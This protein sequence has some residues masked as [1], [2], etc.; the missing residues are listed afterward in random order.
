MTR[1][2]RPL[3]GECELTDSLTP[4]IFISLS[5]NYTPFSILSIHLG[6]VRHPQEGLSI[7]WVEHD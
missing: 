3:L 4:Q 5:E 1:A 6:N 2:N 7:R